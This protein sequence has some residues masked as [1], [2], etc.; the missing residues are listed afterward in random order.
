MLRRIQVEP[1]DVGRL[2]FELG[3]IA[4]HVAIQPVRLGSRLCPDP[5]HR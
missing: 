4:D 5:L 3:I 2:V 1:N